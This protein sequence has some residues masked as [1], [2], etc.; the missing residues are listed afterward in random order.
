MKLLY[1]LILLSAFSFELKAIDFKD[2]NDPKLKAIEEQLKKSKEQDPTLKNNS[3]YKLLYEEEIAS[4]QTCSHCPKYLLLTEQINKVVDKIAKDPKLAISDEVPLRI[5]NLK[6]LFY[7]QAIHERNGKLKCQ[8]FMDLT[9]DLKPTKF[10][11]QFKLVAEDILPYSSIASMQYMN[12]DLEETVYYYRGVDGDKNNIVQAIFTRT[13]GKFRYFK[14]TP[15][16]NEENPYNLPDLGNSSAPKYEPTPASTYVFKPDVDPNAGPPAPPSFTDNYKLTFKTEVEKQNKYVPKN[17]H[18]AAGSMEQVLIDGFSLKGTTDLSLKG[19]QAKVAFKNGQS[20]L[21]QVELETKLSGKTDH[22]IL[23][24][25]SVRVL[26]VLPEVKG[27][28]QQNSNEQV[29]N[30]NLTDKG[31]DYVRTQYKKNTNTDKTS[32]VL[33]RDI[34]ISTTEA[35]S[36]QYGKGE[37]DNRYLVL[38]HTKSIKTHI[39]MALDVRIDENK[40]ATLLYQVS[41]KF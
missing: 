6:F 23:I 8:R 34:P 28:V 7:T 31:V 24:P 22:K 14:Y 21:V 16:A 2:F 20:D 39:T 15:T 4:D 1:S 29:L 12:P 18:F 36:I 10:D 13:G 9:P 38:R 40:H 41:A 27:N 19:N 35:V 37:D 5:N 33:A 17:V 3:Y 26:D 25:F 32:Y 11:G 30:L